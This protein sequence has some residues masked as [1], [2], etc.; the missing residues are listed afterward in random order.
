MAIYY[1][2]R[3]K[4]EMAE[5]LLKLR[6]ILNPSAFPANRAR[7]RE[8]VDLLTQRRVHPAS[9]FAYEFDRL[10]RVWRRLEAQLNSS[11]HPSQNSSP[12]PW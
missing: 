1:T 2:E 9:E 11:E 12:E 8:L 7:A 5:W 6:G 4:N 10:R 3:Q